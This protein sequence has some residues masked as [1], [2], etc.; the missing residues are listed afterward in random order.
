MLR[1]SAAFDDIDLARVHDYLSR[2]S[3]WAAG[4]PMDTLELERHMQRHD[5]DI[6]RR[7]G[8]P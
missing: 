3:Y 8:C 5:P 2:E 7:P 6:Y 4:I 1:T